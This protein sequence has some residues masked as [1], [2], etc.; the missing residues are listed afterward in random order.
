MRGQEYIK[1]VATLKLD[2]KKC[3]GCGLCDIVCP[4][5]VFRI[6]KNKATII[7]R[8]LCMECGACAHN[9]PAEAIVVKS[10][11]G[12]AAGILSG[13]FRGTDPVCDCSEKT[14]KTCC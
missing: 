9:C 8:D 12:C 10:G 4:Q 14:D 2:T 1:N 6:E 13:L 11:V 3:T 5:R 7:S